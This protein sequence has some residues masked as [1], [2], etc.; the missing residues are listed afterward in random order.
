MANRIKGITV[1]IGGD[2]TGLDKAL[3]DVNSTIKN[4]Q[5][6]LKDVERLLKLD[7]TNTELLNQKQRLL[8]ETI[9]ATKDKLEALKTAQEQAKQQME[10]GELGRDKYDALQREIIETEQELDNLI[11]KA[12]DANV[13]MVKLGDAGKK[14]EEAGNKIAGVGESLTKSVTGPIVA[15]G[16][17]SVA[18]FTE[19]D[20]AMDNVISKTG[21]TGEEFEKMQTAVENIATSI[22]TDFKTA[23]DAV[24]EVATRF[25]D[26]GDSLEDLSGKFVRFASLN[27]V[28]VVTAVNNVQAS[29]AAFGVPTKDAGAVLDTLNA[30]AQNTGTDVNQLT[31]LMT[32]NAGVMKEMGYSYEDAAS[33]MGELNK[34]GVDVSSTMTGL[35]KA[36]QTASKDGKDMSTVLGDMND[37][38][39]NAKTDQEAYQKAID[40]FGAKAGPAIAQA[41]RDGRL[42]L[43]DLNISME[44]YAGNVEETF[45][46]TQDPIDQ[47]T[48]LMNNLKLIGS[49]LASVAQ[50][51]L[52]PIFEKL[53][54]KVQQLREWWGGLSD[55]QQQSIIK[56]AG[57]AA[58]IGPALVGIGKI[59]SGVGKGVQAFSSLGKGI[60][61]LTSKISVAGGPMSALK[62]AIGGISAPVLGV[63]AAVAILVAAFVHL[64]KNNE[65]FRDK[66]TG[67]WNSVREK[68]SE[69]GQ[70]ITEAIN[71]L[72][73]NFQGL[74]DAIKSAWDWL[75]NA[76]EPL[77]SSVIQNI[78]DSLKG[79]IDIVTGIVQTIAGII[80]GFKDGD[81]ALALEGLKT[82]WDGIWAKLTAPVNA[83]ISIISGYLEMFGTSW[84]EVW[85]GI[86]DFFTGV[87]QGISSF[88]TDTWTG[89]K[90]TF[91]TVWNAISNTVSTVWEKIKNVVKVGI[92][93]IKELFSAAFQILTVPFRFIWENCKE[94]VTTA[95]NFIKEKISTVLTSIKTTISTVW[96]SIKSSLQP[97]LDG[98]KTNISTA[99]ETVKTN[100]TGKVEA[101]KTSVT[102][103][104]N[105]IK[106]TLDPIVEGIK[107]S[108]TTAW[109]AAKTNISTALE[110]I[111]TNVSTAWENVKTTVSNA[112][113]NVKTTISNGFETAKTTVSNIFE[114]IKTTISNAL[115]TAKTTVSNAIETIKGL[116]NFD[117]SFPPLKLPH[118]A[119]VGEFSLNPPSVPHLS[120]EWYKKAMNRGMI[121]N[122]ATI[123]GM[124][125]NSLLAG[126]E[127]GSETVVGTKSLMN[128]IGQAVNS[129]GKKVEITNN[130]YVNGYGSDMNKLAQKVGEVI[131]NTTVQKL[132]MSGS[133]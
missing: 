72:G 132:R 32:Q 110:N 106:S 61:K 35:K 6:Q 39:K 123:F 98:I 5:G 67:I 27:G 81:W 87:W 119:I 112:V 88:F 111:K 53:R 49:D 109:D 2:V 114:N 55:E 79:T 33:F 102:N 1:E 133:W 74:G 118:F 90:T 100:V 58:A 10:S 9:G 7:P 103:T 52:I 18:A 71:S 115:E 75:C 65:E 20:S 24:G 62:G 105:S 70:K 28:D 94:A 38:I 30:I 101:V 3:K 68:F 59:T 13:A 64:W 121:L 128:M 85:T 42:S 14:I 108:I 23:S 47:T 80:K 91:E 48:L 83:V 25:D 22:P 89:I 45:D 93:F 26:V 16:A 44:T 66:V 41:V 51:M 125:G 92:L 76:L 43:E 36:W 129:A 34:N 86:K 124:N 19:V 96:N 56:F 17:A 57:I 130:V 122:G 120:V 84:E 99:W 97:I 46:A 29:M 4:T 11:D 40:L 95:W 126:G 63:V 50:E 73:F 104:W 12:G 21:A 54:E 78:A 82:I 15:I 107:T 77:V 113:D 131:G 37:T 8:S 117:W 69:A 127:A 60:S 31:T 116:F